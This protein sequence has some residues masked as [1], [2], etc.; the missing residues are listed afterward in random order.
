MRTLLIAMV[1]LVEGLDGAQQTR[2][3]SDFPR[4]GD[5]KVTT[6]RVDAVSCARGP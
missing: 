6:G 4:Q 2:L 3:G 1:G 5:A